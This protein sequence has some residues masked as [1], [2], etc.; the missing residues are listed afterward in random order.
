[1]ADDAS[2]A[3]IVRST[4]D[5]ARNLGLEVVAEGVETDEVLG[6]LADAALRRR[7]G[8]PASAARCRRP[9]STAGSPRALD[10]PRDR[11]EPGSGSLPRRLRRADL[12]RRARPR[13][14]P[15]GPR[16][17]A[18][19]R[20]GGDVLRA[21]AA[22]R[23]ATRELVA[24]DPRRAATP[25]SCTATATCA[26]PTSTARRSRRHSTRARRA[27]RARRPPAPLAH[28]VGRRRPPGRAALAAEH[29][30]ELVGWTSTRTTGAA[31]APRRC[32]PPSAPSCATARSCSLTTASARARC[33][34][35]CEETRRAR[36]G[37]SRA[38]ARPERR[39]TRRHRRRSCSAP[40]D[41]T[42]AAGAAERDR[43]RPPSRPTRSTPSPR[44]RAGARGRAPI[45]SEWALALRARRARR[46]LGRADPRRPPQRRRAPALLAPPSRCATREL[47]A[48]AAG[49][50][51]LGRLGRRPA[52]G[53]GE[54]A[55]V[56]RGDALR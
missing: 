6:D 22:R 31:T 45:A 30:L 32:S 27:R 17:A 38:R 51:W 21:R 3:A 55:R 50:R 2:D 11:E 25:S 23:G 24:R 15:R 34:T 46:R 28:A 8:L 37:C 20:R 14:D 1:M 47:A 4:I 29:G 35:G 39:V 12:R 13:L 48:I 43:D 19:R 10:R 9:S 5:L 16:R 42:I 56:G 41:A 33:A 52:P 54:P 7:P 18:R 26:T 40:L 36:R 49:R 53:E 44:R